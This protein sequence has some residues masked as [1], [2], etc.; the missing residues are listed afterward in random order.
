MD[1][2][3]LTIKETSIIFSIHINTVYTWIRKGFITYIRIGDKPKSPYR[4][5]R[6]AIEAIHNSI[7]KEMSQKSQKI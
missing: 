1:K 7:L 3:F 2:E 6:K 5:S 4:I